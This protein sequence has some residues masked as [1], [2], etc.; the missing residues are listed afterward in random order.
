M[1]AGKKFKG[2][3]NQK[4]TYTQK[5]KQIEGQRLNNKEGGCLMYNGLKDTKKWKGCC[6]ETFFAHMFLNNKSTEQIYLT[7]VTMQYIL[8]NLIS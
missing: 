8:R 1:R 2:K 6:G 5:H 3:Y 4:E 7:V